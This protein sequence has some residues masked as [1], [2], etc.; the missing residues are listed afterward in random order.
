MLRIWLKN[1]D[2]YDFIITKYRVFIQ[3]YFWTYNDERTSDDTRKSLF[4][5]E[6]LEEYDKVLTITTNGSPIKITSFLRRQIEKNNK[7]LVRFIIPK[8][9]VGAHIQC[10]RSMEE[11][12][13]GKE[14]E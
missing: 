6:K 1:Q 5:H 13:V 11:H 10:L 9:I 12:H 8:M 14:M 4:G 7:Y 3:N 2:D